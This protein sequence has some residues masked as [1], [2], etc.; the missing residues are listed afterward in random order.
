MQFRIHTSA[1]SAGFSELYALYKGIFT[2]EDEAEDLDGIRASLALVGDA[3]LVRTC[4]AFNE[5]WVA[6]EQDGAVVG[7]VNFTAFEVPALGITTAHINYLFTSA[8]WRGRGVGSALLEE[9][10]AVSRADYL[11]CEQNDPSLM[12]AAELEEDFRSSGIDP[13]ERIAWWTR[14]GFGRLGFRYVQPP[15]SPGKAPAEGM[16]LNVCPSESPLDAKVLQAHLRRFF[17]ISVLK[18]RTAEGNPAV[19]QMLS[20]VLD[21]GEVAI[22]TR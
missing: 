16:S 22:S 14:R 6:A 2:D 18:S 20:E 21:L 11:F 15:L 8:A 19:E 17:Y 9:V 12:S 1:D 4:G 3:G 7:G 13:L 10:K 5:Y